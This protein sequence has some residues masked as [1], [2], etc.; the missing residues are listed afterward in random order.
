[1][2][3]TIARTAEDMAQSL[4]T[5][6]FQLAQENRLLLEDLKKAHDELHTLKS[7]PAKTPERAAIRP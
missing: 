1:M 3:K 6:N 5:Q 7:K 4:L 2:T